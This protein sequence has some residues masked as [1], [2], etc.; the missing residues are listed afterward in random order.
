MAFTTFVENRRMCNNLKKK[1]LFRIMLP[2]TMTPYILPKNNK[3]VNW[4]ENFYFKQ[5][6]ASLYYVSFKN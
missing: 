5:L 1:N 2:D 3:F 6:V 4:Y